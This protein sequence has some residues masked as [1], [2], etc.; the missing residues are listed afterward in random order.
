MFQTTLKIFVLLHISLGFAL[1]AFADDDAASIERGR[2]LVTIGG[3]ND[4]HTAGFAENAGKVPESEWLTGVPVGFNGPWGTSYP[5]NL[6]LV[7]SRLN[8]QQFIARARS[9][10]LPPMPWFNLVSASDTDMQ[11]IYRFIA[12]LGPA[13][14]DTP[15]YVAP[16]E[17][18]K[19]P[20]IVFVPTQGENLRTVA[21]VN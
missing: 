8:E 9:Q 16:G 13:G 14:A 12:S 6:R 10:M 7:A 3:C 5:A 4:C 11:S 18:P 15:A 2:Y 21:T 20:Y 1:H 19:T 17:T